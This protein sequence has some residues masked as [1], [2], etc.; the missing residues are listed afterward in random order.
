MPTLRRNLGLVEAVGVSISMVAP[1][2][3]M[4]FNVTM[5][6]GVTGTA[7]PLAFII[8]MVALLVVGLSFVAFARRVAS[9]GSAYAYITLQFGPLAGFIAGWA[10][11]MTYLVFGSAVSAL[12]GIF[13]DAALGNY[14]MSL[15]RLWVLHGTLALIACMVL[16]Y[17]DMRLATRVMLALETI[18]VLAIV[19]LGV[20]IIRAVAAQSGLSWAP[21][22]PDPH[23]GWAGIGYGLVFAVLSFAGFEG[24]ATL[25]EEA[26]E[27]R[28]AIPIAVIGTVLLTGVFYV[29]SA[30]TQVIGYGLDHMRAL[31]ADSAPLNT[32]ALR[33]GSREFAT[34]LDLAA[35]VSAFSATLSALSAASR[36]VFALGRAGLAPRLGV[37]HPHYGTPA[38]AVVTAGLFMLAGVL[39]WAPVIG[40]ADYFDDLGTIGMLMLV[41][42]CVTVGAAV[43]AVRTR[44]PAWIATGG[45]GTVLMLWPLYNSV[46][47]VP[48]FPGNL[49]PYLVIAYLLVGGIVLLLRPVLVRAVLAEAV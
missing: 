45:L 43:H 12:V 6:A 41:Y 23:F 20:L 3:G 47:P 49:W 38:A 28:R 18:S 40:A 17:R 16:A 37:A 19:V 33:Y 7:A 26:G 2:T 30:Y 8:G 11:M 39:C 42:L 34:A 9:A 24:A 14:H 27:P 1:T 5:E 29:F 13:V 48:A 31:A 22:L 4:A 21:F 15:P 10:L 36:M 46:Y 25:G 35:A 44:R 32:L